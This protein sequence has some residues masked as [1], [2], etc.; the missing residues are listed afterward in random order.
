MNPFD[1]PSPLT[2]EDSDQL[3]ED[4]LSSELPV[5]SD[6]KKR[7]YP[8]C[9]N[10]AAKHGYRY[11]RLKHLDLPVYRTDHMAALVG[12]LH[13]RM[14]DLT[15]EYESDD[16]IPFQGVVAA[17]IYRQLLGFKSPRQLVRH[18]RQSDYKQN[19]PVHELLG[20]SS[21]PHYNTLQNAINDRFNTHTCEFIKRWSNILGVVGLR[22]GYYFPDIEDRQLSNNGGITEISI[23]R[24]RGYAHGA[25]DLL[26]DDM[27]ITKNEELA[28]WTD[29]GI[30]FDYSLHLCALGTLP[31]PSWRT[32]LTTVPSERS[33]HLRGC[34]DLSERHLSRRCCRVERDVRPLDAK[35][36][37]CRLS[38]ITS[39]TTAADLG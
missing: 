26:R 9:V 6:Y 24:K 10:L 21:I 27:P 5:E 23:E 36:A 29:Y 39:R 15:D 34:R 25:L 7:A 14:S 2:K 35:T 17:E 19:V 33:R 32:S 3:A 12:L 4:L 11:S 13:M 31:R 22:R 38:Q 16:S 20:L 18:F 28:T 37:R 30:H 8:L 1:G